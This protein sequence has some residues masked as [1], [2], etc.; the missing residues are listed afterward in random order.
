MGIGIVWLLSEDGA[1][2]ENL[3]YGKLSGNKI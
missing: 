1:L 2:L 3:I